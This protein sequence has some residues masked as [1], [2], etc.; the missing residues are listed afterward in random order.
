MSMQERYKQ[1]H[2]KFDVGASED[3]LRGCFQ[4]MKEIARNEKMFILVMSHFESNGD[5][6]QS[7]EIPMIF[8]HATCF[9]E[10]AGEDYCIDVNHGEVL[11]WK[12]AN[13]A[14]IASSPVAQSFTVKTQWTAADELKQRTELDKAFEKYFK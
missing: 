3:S 14:A 12:L 2:D 10:C 11:G 1:Y 13:P 7:E 8:F 6:H 9:K 5:L 4:C